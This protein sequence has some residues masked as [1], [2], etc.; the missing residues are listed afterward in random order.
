MRAGQ[1]RGLQEDDKHA[2]S[3]W[4]P[5]TKSWLHAWG[6][7]IILYYIILYYII[8]YYIILYYIIL[9]YIILYYIILYYII[10]T[11]TEITGGG[12]VALINITLMVRVYALL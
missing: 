8:L 2:G 1:A 5:K 10:Y 3:F 9:Y 11:A 7:I 6:V 12:T 4:R